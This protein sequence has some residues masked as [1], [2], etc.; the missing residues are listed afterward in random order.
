MLIFR[1][2]TREHGLSIRDGSISR[3][4]EMSHQKIKAPRSPP[5]GDSWIYCAWSSIRLLVC[6]FS[7]LVIG[8]V[9]AALTL[10]GVSRQPRRV[11]R[12]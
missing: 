3:R 9:S 8:Q 2:T 6:L 11:Y 12:R 4:P 7:L 10:I 1:A 5:S